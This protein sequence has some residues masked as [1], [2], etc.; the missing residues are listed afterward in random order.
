VLLQL[1]VEILALFGFDGQP[2]LHCFSL[3]REPL[4]PIA[5]CDFK[6]GMNE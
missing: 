1:L 4:G 6:D 5:R 2:E 3:V